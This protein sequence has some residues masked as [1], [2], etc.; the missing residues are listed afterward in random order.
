MHHFEWVINFIFLS[1][2]LYCVFVVVRQVERINV[3]TSCFVVVAFIAAFHPSYFMYANEYIKLFA[4][5][6]E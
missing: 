5:N 6:R 1:C 2:S 3:M 4:N